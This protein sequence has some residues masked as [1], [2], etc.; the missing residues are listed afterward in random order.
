MFLGLN[1]KFA[2]IYNELS[3]ETLRQSILYYHPCSYKFKLKSNDLICNK[4]IDIFSQDDFKYKNFMMSDLLNSND[5]NDKDDGD[6]GLASCPV[7][8]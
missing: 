6:D 7:I 5:D 1:K 8:V 2:R 3:N 4:F